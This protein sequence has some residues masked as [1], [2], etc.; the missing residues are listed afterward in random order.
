MA[1]E[2]AVVLAKALRDTAEPFAVYE[3]VR[4]PRVE[5]NIATSA[6]LTAGS[7]RQVPPRAAPVGED[8]LRRQLDWDIPLV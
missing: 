4:R 1:L 2:D 7:T 3:R 6:R 8:E 5:H